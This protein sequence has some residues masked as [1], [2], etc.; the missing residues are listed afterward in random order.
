M[1][2]KKIMQLHSDVEKEM[3]YYRDKLELLGKEELKNGVTNYL[4]ARINYCHGRFEALQ[5][6]L[7]N[8]HDNITSEF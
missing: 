3:A 4:S 7:T 6:V 1:Q 2:D 8:L 5:W